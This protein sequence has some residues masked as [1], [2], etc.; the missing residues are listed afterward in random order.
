M[1]MYVIIN[2]NIKGL[3]D[4]LAEQTQKIGCKSRQSLKILKNK[5]K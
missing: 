1:Q 3:P 4:E 5:Y 2:K